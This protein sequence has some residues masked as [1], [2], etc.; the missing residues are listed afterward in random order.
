MRHPNVVL[1]TLPTYTLGCVEIVSVYMLNNVIV[2]CTPVYRYIYWHLLLICASGKASTNCCSTMSGGVY[3]GDEVGALV[4]D[5]GH[6][7]LRYYH[8]GVYSAFES[9][10]IFCSLEKIIILSRIYT[11]VFFV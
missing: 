8:R 11:P 10:A 5:P 3:G 9:P 6:Y 1:T 2:Y 7:S 4:F